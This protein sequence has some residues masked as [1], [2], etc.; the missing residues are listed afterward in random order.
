MFYVAA[1]NAIFAFETLIMVLFHFFLPAPFSPWTEVFADSGALL[2]FLVPIVYFFVYRPLTINILE[3]K[4]KEQELTMLQTI[5][6]LIAGSHDFNSALKTTLE[7]IGKTT[8][9][10]LGEIWLP[11]PDRTHLELDGTWRIENKRLK[12]FVVWS[13]KFTFP[14]GEG[15]P[16]RAWSS[17]E[18]VSPVDC[19]ALR[20][21][22]PHLFVDA[23]RNMRCPHAGEGANQ[24]ICAPLMGHG[25]VLGVFY[26]SF[27]PPDTLIDKN[28]IEAKHRLVTDAA[29]RIGLSLANLNL[30]N[31]IKNMSILDALTGLYNRRY[32]EESLEREIYRARRKDAPLGVVMLDI[33]HFKQFN[34]HYGHEAGDDILREI[35]ALLQ[36]NIRG[37]DIACRYGGEEFIL[38]LP[39][40]TLEMTRLRAEQ[41]REAI[42]HIHVQHGS[43]SLG[44]VTLSFGVAAFPDRGSTV[45]DIVKMADTA[46]YK[47]KAEGRNRVCVAKAFNYYK[48]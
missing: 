20:L 4:H 28:R 42:K 30:L 7:S 12:K 47:A 1:N 2:I 9:W 17:K 35:G 13:K 48:F 11:S 16:G 10:V 3:C 29:E 39:E 22:R 40:A 38:I 43:Q 32:M 31:T 15:L 41:L 33:D 26:S 36:R 6:E 23:K 45:D 5:T 14:Q 46:L 21:G 24:H 18:P 37:S 27:E 19:Y 8:G 25:E 34:D 44:T